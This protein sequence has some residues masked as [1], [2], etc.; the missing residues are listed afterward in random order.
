[1]TLPNNFWKSPPPILP[2]NVL[3]DIDTFLNSPLTTI[4][5]NLN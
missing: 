3:N 2:V 5:R 1:L 4:F